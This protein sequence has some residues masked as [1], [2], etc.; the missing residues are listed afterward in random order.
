MVMTAAKWFSYIDTRVKSQEEKEKRSFTWYHNLTIF[1]FL[2][3][4][5]QKS[6]L[7]AAHFYLL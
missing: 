3:F 4:F 5:V 6:E 7:F 2:N 1:F